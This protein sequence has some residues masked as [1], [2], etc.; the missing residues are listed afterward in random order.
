M[1]F[2]QSM[3]TPNT[4]SEFM[5]KNCIKIADFSNTEGKERL[6]KFLKMFLKM[7]S[8]PEQQDLEH[9]FVST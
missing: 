5:C 2:L 4:I 6:P 1:T 8:A 3:S 7:N 9:P